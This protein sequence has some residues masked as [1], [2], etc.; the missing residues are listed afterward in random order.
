MNKKFLLL[1]LLIL[2]LLSIQA[3]EK[4]KTTLSC[5]I[6]DYRGEMIYYDCV[7]TP[8]IRAEFHNNPGESHVYEFE[9]DD[10][11]TLIV[12][13]REQFVMQPGDSLH[14]KVTYEGRNYT[15]VEYSGTPQAVLIANTLHRIRMHR[16][17]VRYKA[18]LPAALVVLTDPIAY[19]QA[20]L[21]E[22]RAEKA[23]LNEI[24]AEIPE[25][26][27]NYLLSE[28]D[29]IFLPNLIMYPYA[30]AA[31]QKKELKD[32]IADDYWTALDDYQLRDDEASLRNRNYMSFLPSY[33]KYEIC[34]RNGCDPA[35]FKTSQSR[36]SEYEELAGFYEGALRDAALF[37]IIYNGLVGDGRDFELC[38]N[39]SKDY[40][41]KYNI[42]KEYKQIL[43]EIMK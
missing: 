39:L 38:R 3:N 34:K 35:T 8:F 16:R 36:E 20:S 2:P 33:A 30:C 43:K 29:A 32:C 28:L 6:Y 40:L 7:Q 24:K 26:V 12:N 1:I 9:T 41:K 11:V 17:E 31:Y 19:H 14:A 18:N 10:I 42:S 5:Q 23:I 13:G 22:W 21:D 37:V 4:V 25:R 27:Y 15:A